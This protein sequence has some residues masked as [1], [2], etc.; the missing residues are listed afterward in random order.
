M[1]GSNLYIK[2]NKVSVINIPHYKGLQVRELLKFASLKIN[3]E[4]YL[5]EYQYCKEPNREWLCNVINTLILKEFHEF[6]QE[7]I[8]IRRDELIE[9][10]SLGIRVNP[11]FA[12]L[13]AKSKAVSTMKGKS[14]FLTRMPKVNKDLQRIMQLE[15]EIKESDSKER[16]LNKEIEELKYKIQDF[17]NQQN[18]NNDNLDKLSNLYK[19]GIIDDNGCLINNKME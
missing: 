8:D 9:S 12:E 6:I 7:K 11:E 1:N 5:P 4:D 2:C 10:Q 18:E 15:E 14:H 3:I 19:L 13:F 16:A 17:E